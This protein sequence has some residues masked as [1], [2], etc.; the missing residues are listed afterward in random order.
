ME[1]LDF[2]SYD[3]NTW[4]DFLKE[5]W[6]V[7]AIALVV[8]LL[9]I[10]IVK[11]VVK[12]ALVAVIVF[13]V[14]VYSGYTMEDL[15]AFGTKLEETTG[16]LKQ[17]AISAM[18]GE[19]KNAKFTTNKDGSYTVATDS[20]ALTG[21]PGT[22]EVSVSYRGNDLFKMQIDETIQ[23]IINQAKQNKP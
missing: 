21:V 17:E 20:V 19:A 12:W 18:I 15:K 3:W 10:R 7:L 4:S 11:T 9:V 16:S 23:S 1:F 14:I 6:F 13:G 22:N 5:H 8:L 2:T